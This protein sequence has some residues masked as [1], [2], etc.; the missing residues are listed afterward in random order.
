MRVHMAD[1]CAAVL[2][3]GCAATG[4]AQTSQTT[5][6]VPTNPVTPQQQ[7]V[8]AVFAVLSAM[9]SHPHDNR[10]FE[11][12]VARYGTTSVTYA[13]YRDAFTPFYD[14]SA[15]F[16]DLSATHGIRGAEDRL[17]DS[18]TKKCAAAG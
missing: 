11:D 17:R 1:V 2:M 7:C 8:R 16:Y 15:P 12:F 18:V 9:V 13:A 4:C 3:I 14:L 5:Q 6:A 10:P